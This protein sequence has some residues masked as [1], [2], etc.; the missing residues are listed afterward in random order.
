M[1]QDIRF[2]RGDEKAERPNTPMDLPASIRSEFRKPEKYLAESGLVDAVNVALLLGQPLLLTGEPGTGKTQL[3]YSLAWELGY[4]E[5]LRFETKSTSKAKDLFYTYDALR[6]F[7]EAQTGEASRSAL[8][9]ITYNALGTA[10]LRTRS[11]SDVHS[12]LPIDFEHNGP[13]RSI[14]LIDEV[15]KAPRDFPNDILNELEELYFRIPEL[16]NEKIEASDKMAPIIIMTSNSE[17]DL[18]DAF[19]RRCIYYNIPFPKRADMERIISN[20]LG[21]YATGNNSFLEHALKLF[22][23]LRE[24]TSGLRKKPS[25]S[26][27]LGW[28]STIRRVYGDTENPLL[29][30]PEIVHET[31][32]N[33]IK[34]AEDQEKA[35]AIIKKWIQD[36]KTQK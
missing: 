29:A 1:N 24:K 31:L 3:A 22:F 26:E 5:P 19:L 28:V 6:R 12:Y 11:K 25:T 20:R 14:V 10:I 30:R 16:G 17:K 27:L 15:D 9:Y 36:Q 35:Q 34:T 8:D 13:C 21:I 33:L 2:Y 4:E 18:P 32:S 23:L 7:H